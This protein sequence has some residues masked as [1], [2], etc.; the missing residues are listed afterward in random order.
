[1]IAQSWGADGQWVVRSASWRDSG[2]IST[3]DFRLKIFIY[4]S[5]YKQ[6]KTSCFFENTDLTNL[7]EASEGSET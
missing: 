1:M 7:R 5:Q 6:K 4:M 3:S 2:L